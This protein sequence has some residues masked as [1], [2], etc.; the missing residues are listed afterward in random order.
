MFLP[1]KEALSKYLDHLKSQ[2]KNPP[3]ILT[4]KEK[5][6]V[7]KLQGTRPNKICRFCGGVCPGKRTAWCSQACVDEFFL[8]CHDPTA[9]ENYITERDKEVCQVCGLDLKRFVKD[10]LETPLD[11]IEQRLWRLEGF[12]SK[13]KLSQFEPNLRGCQKIL[14]ELTR[15]RLWEIDHKVP[16]HQGGGLCPLDQLSTLCLPCHKKKTQRQRNGKT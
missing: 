3:R 8:T 7:E 4:G 5:S 15:R 9:I 10:F 12:V 13:E 11:K 16:V 2:G 6:K 14:A 1:F